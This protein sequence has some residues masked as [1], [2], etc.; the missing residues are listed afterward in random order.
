MREV[1][2]IR[3][4]H[5]EAI[6][7][8]VIDD[9]QRRRIRCLLAVLFQIRQR[10]SRSARTRQRL[11]PADMPARLEPTD[12]AGANYNYEPDEEDI[13]KDI[14]PRNVSVQIF[15]A[16]LENAAGE[17]GAKMT[18]MDNATRNAGDMIDRLTL[19]RNRT[20]Q[21]QI[22]RELIEIISGAEA[23]RSWEIE[24][25]DSIECRRTHHA[26]Y[27]RRRRRAVPGPFAGDLEFARIR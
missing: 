14:L 26:G 10:A 13:L 17:Q 24:H 1:K 20:R 22:T 12:L 2:Q 9:V 15:R 5:A 27:G 25:G 8:R 6:G 3:F 19:E 7:N 21:A 18:A 16:L 4:E 11:I 23:L